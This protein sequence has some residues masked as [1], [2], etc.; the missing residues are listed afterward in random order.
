MLLLLALVGCD[1]DKGITVDTKFH[2]QPFSAVVDSELAAYFV[3]SYLHNQKN[4]SRFDEKIA[5]LCPV[6]SSINALE[7]EQIT[8][9][10]SHDFA[11]LCLANALLSTSRNQ[12]ADTYF[13][14]WLKKIAKA[15]DGTSI[16]SELPRDLN[17]LFV[18]GWLYLSDTTTGADFKKQRDLLSSH[19][20]SNRLI[21]TDE[22][23]TIEDNAK[24]IA[25]HIKD[26]ENASGPTILVSASKGGAETALALHLV[27][28]NSLSKRNLAWINVGGVLRGT[29]LADKAATWPWSWFAKLFVLNGRSASGIQGLQTDESIKRSTEIGSL[30]D[31]IVLNYVGIPMQ[32]QVADRAKVG[33]SLMKEHGP[34]DGLTYIVDAIQPAQYGHT[35]VGLGLDHYFAH[36]DIDEITLALAY[37][38]V[39]LWATKGL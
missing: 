21:P 14:T 22:N 35:I 29:V 30:K 5:A 27:R 18:P 26:S 39:E 31:L 7:L 6:G 28:D 36:Q 10:S 34:N 37:T 2:N 15:R 3:T 23:G 8:L 20:I 9:K 4:D 11:S 33:F 38:V 13:T 25:S 12:R 19:G 1:G 16:E 24:I 17:I 32:A